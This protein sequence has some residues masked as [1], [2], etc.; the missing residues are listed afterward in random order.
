MKPSGRGFDARLLAALIAVMLCAAATAQGVPKKYQTLYRQLDGELAAFDLNVPT[1]RAGKPPIRAAALNSADCHRGEILLESATREIT[2]RELDALK[3]LGAEGIVL[4]VCYPL[5]TPQFRDP[6]PFIDYYTNIANEV[7]TRNL[8]LL[9]EHGTLQPALVATDVRP[10]YVKLTKPRFMR[11]R[12]AE[13]K[14]I[15]VALQPDYV[16]L[17]SEPSTQN[18]G[19]KLTV[20]DWRSYVARSVDMLAEQLGSFP[21]LLGAGSATSEDISYVE[22]FS[23]ISGLHYIDLHWYPVS[24]VATDS[25]QR[26][27]SWPDR[28]RAIDPAKQIVMSEVWLYKLTAGEK[29]SGT[30]GPDIRAR[31]VYEFWAPLDQKFL[32][33]AGRAARAKNTEWIAASS[34]RCFFSYLDYNDPLTFRMNARQLIDLAGQRAYSAILNN[35]ITETGAAFREM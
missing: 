17:V 4:H 24:S 23:S 10:Y 16:T 5:L 25:L 27:L 14:T 2:L 32:R 26:I 22:A 8:K 11:E 21:T 3:N 30:I 28:I 12:Y 33:I 19:L 31:D 6:Q 13:L 9:I 35:Q 34:S 29:W 18:A 7:R 15:L 20:K 1:A